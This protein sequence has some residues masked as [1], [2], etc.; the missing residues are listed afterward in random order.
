MQPTPTTP[1]AGQGHYRA[2]ELLGLEF[3]SRPTAFAP[4]G[5]AED[6]TCLALPLGREADGAPLEHGVLKSAQ[7][8]VIAHWSDD[9]SATGA[10]LTF[11]DPGQAKAFESWAKEQF[12][13]RCKSFVPWELERR[14]GIDQSGTALAALRELRAFARG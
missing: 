9:M 1:R 3:A 11:L 7:G 13:Q 2:R 8:E 14:T 12:L 5:P 6:Y 4:P 10:S